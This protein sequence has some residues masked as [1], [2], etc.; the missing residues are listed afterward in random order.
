MTQLDKPRC[1]WPQGELMITYHDTEWGRPRHDDPFLYEMLFLEGFQAGLSWY[2]VLS[3]REAFRRV[4]SNFDPVAVA[5]YGESDIA[6]LMQAEGI[7]RNRLKVQAAVTNARV[8]LDIQKE[9]GSFA[10]YLWG[11]APNGPIVSQQD[12]FP[13]SSPLSDAVFKD[14]K[15]RGMKF[16]G[17]V[18]VYSYL[19][20]V[21]VINDHEQ[22]CFVMR[23]LT[24]G[25]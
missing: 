12:V 14:L 19:E 8:F 22:G 15:K 7:V 18:T 16:V 10:A 25:Q 24:G 11:F 13:T 21:G 20:S 17:T 4:F 9:F 6:R 23:E 5:A 2:I 1:H 3:K